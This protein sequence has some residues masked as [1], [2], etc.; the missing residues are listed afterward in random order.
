MTD[1]DDLFADEV[2][3]APSV[4]AN[5]RLLQVIGSL[6]VVGVLIAVGVIVVVSALSSITARGGAVC[7]G[8][9]SCTGLSVEQVRALTAIGLPDGSDVLESS[10]TETD[11]L[12]TVT[13]RVQLPEGAADPFEG[14]GYGPISSP[15]L[16]WPLDG[17]SVL[18]FYGAT[19]EQ[20]TLNAEA[21]F[22]VDD[23]LREIVLV[24]ITRALD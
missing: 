8:A 6:V 1:I 15:R 18:E 3:V 24:Q 20:G 2:E 13:A 4:A 22:A 11:E 16:D 19:G 9:A 14:T 17:L 10:Y 12:I 7:G 23:R 5:P 21:V